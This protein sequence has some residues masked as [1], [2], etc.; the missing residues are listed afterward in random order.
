MRRKLW[1]IALVGALILVGCDTNPSTSG[2]IDSSSDY[3]DDSSSTYVGDGITSVTLVGDDHVTLTPIN[4]DYTTDGDLTVNN[5]GYFD[6]NVT[7]DD[8]YEL[9][10]LVA[11]GDEYSS[12]Y[13]ISGSGVARNIVVTNGED[14]TIT[15]T[16][17]ASASTVVPDEI[18]DV[19]DEIAAPSG[20]ELTYTYGLYF[21]SLNYSGFVENMT[22]QYT[23]SITTRDVSGS[24]RGSMYFAKTEDG[25][26]G[27]PSLSIDGTTSYTSPF[28]NGFYD[29]D[30]DAAR[31][32]THNPLEL[33]GLEEGTDSYYAGDYDSE[34]VRERFNYTETAEDDVITYNLNLKTEYLTDGFMLNWFI[35]GFAIGDS[36]VGGSAYNATS[37][38]SFTI[39]FDNNRNFSSLTIYYLCDSDYSGYGSTGDMGVIQITNVSDPGE[40]ENEFVLNTS[41]ESAAALENNELLEKIAAGESYTMEIKPH[42]QDANG[43]DGIG[44]DGWPNGYTFADKAANS[45]TIYSFDN[46]VISTQ[47][48]PTSWTS[49][50]DYYYGNI[51]HPDYDTEGYYAADLSDGTV[52]LY[53]VDKDLSN[54]TNNTFIYA[55]PDLRGTL[56]TPTVD[57]FTIDMTAI[58]YHFF[59]EVSD[60][61]YNF[62]IDSDSFLL[63]ELDD[64]LIDALTSPL[65]YL[66]GKSG[67]IYSSLVMGVIPVFGGIDGITIDLSE[68]DQV[69]LTIDIRYEEWY[70]DTIYNV[71]IDYVFTDIG[72]TTA[73]TLD[74]TAKAINTAVWSA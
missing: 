34:L 1:G 26:V 23:D 53:T 15:A 18:L 39:T 40:L 48:A 38:S 36:G 63:G 47:V 24:L 31:T 66:F 21:S 8:G 57:D 64:Q 35:P 30:S 22:S 12:R 43:T 25:K 58:N 19:V 10:T 5:L 32:Y 51:S 67:V 49:S 3:S 2:S 55:N 59:T 45:G 74:D 14:V 69:T 71:S 52:N 60:G 65:D 70:W 61:V 62:S 50:Y 73:D 41:D 44:Y 42:A 13:S 9:V 72:S 56:G 46:K 4:P 54:P 7:V 27:S 11:S 20:V 68:T 6:F 28:S 16:S 33:L 17:Q 37:I 29:W